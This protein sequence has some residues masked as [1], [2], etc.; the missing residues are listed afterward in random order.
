MSFR[1]KIDKKLLRKEKSYETK[2]LMKKKRSDEYKVLEEVLDRST[3]ITLYD[4]LSKGTIAEIYGA[5][6]SGKEAKIYWG[7]GPDGRDLA[8]KIFLTVSSEFRKGKLIYI[9]G[10]PRFAYIRR[11]TRSLINAWT[12]KEFKNLQLAHKVGVSVPEPIAVS[13]NVLIMTF[14]GE[15]GVSAPLIKETSLKKPYQTYRQ[16]LTYV[17]KLYQKA[18]LVHADLS[19]Y[20]IMIWRGKPVLFDFS[21]GVSIEHM[22]ADNFLRRDLK[23]LNRYFKKLGV[24]VPSLE[25]MYGSVTG[26]KS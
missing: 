18:E 22:M 20:N 5:V 23:N 1:R 4:F 19:E 9:E 16:I 12:L 24:D 6:K 17:K 25:E 14:I 15:K 7:R 13:N 2:Q 3:V 11:D 10:D 26:G 21:Q 8:I